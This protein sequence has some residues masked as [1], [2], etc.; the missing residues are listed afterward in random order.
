MEPVQAA[1]TP[2]EQSKPVPSGA[3]ITVLRGFYESLEVPVAR[4]WIVIG[5]GRGSDLVLAERTISRMHAAIGFDGDS[6]FIQDL[7][8]TN[9][10]LVNGAKQ[11]RAPLSDDDQIQMG[12]LLLRFRAP[13]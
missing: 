11:Q 13:N 6:F 3:S 2:R 1:A 5:R 4:D 8:S 10:T 7:E 9:G 12:R